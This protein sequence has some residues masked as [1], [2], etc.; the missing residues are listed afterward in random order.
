MRPFNAAK[1]QFVRDYLRKL[2]RATKGCTTKAAKVAGWSVP[3]FCQLLRR[4]RM[5]ASNYR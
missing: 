4:Y 3:N 5:K 2:L 1:E